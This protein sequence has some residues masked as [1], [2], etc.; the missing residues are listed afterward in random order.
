MR[1]WHKNLIHYL[2][3]Q[4]L[5]GQWRECCLIAKNIKE[6]GTPN[7][8][9]VNKIIEYPI[10]HLYTYGKA[11]Y[12][13]MCCRGYK[14]DLNKFDKYFDD[15]KKKLLPMHK[16]FIDWHNDLYMVICYY[17]LKEKYMNNGISEKEWESIYNYLFT[18]DR[19]RKRLI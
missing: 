1:L 10:E 15:N 17:N 14:V 3:R 18:I 8:I 7:H 6:N 5:L 4:Q 12:S 19:I 9:L 16:I 13:E 11:I 2:P